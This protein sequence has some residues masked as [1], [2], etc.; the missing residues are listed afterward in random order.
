MN[1][2]IFLFTLKVVIKLLQFYWVECLLLLKMEMVGLSLIIWRRQNSCISIWERLGSYSNNQR[3]IIL[4]DWMHFKYKS[5]KNLL[6]LDAQNNNNVILHF[7]QKYPTLYQTEFTIKTVQ[8]ILNSSL[9]T[10]DLEMTKNWWIWLIWKYQNNYFT[11]KCPKNI[12]LVWCLMMDHNSS[13]Q[14]SVWFP[15]AGKPSHIKIPQEM[16]IIEYIN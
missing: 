2:D 4:L 8:K 11:W 9:R 5:G 10:A 1:L 12:S 15:R 16:V 3:L 13:Q 7:Q 14:F 6:K